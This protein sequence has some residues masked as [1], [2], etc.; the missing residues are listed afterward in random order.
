MLAFILIMSLL[1][2]WFGGQAYAASGYIINTIAGTNT[3]GYSGDGDAATS[4]SLNGPTGVAV[5]S[6]GNLY[7][8]D[9]LNHR[10][11]KV[12]ASGK[13]STVAGTGTGGYSGDEVTATSAYLN[14]PKGVAI[15][16]SG[17]LYIADT[18]SQRIRKVDV[19][20]KISTVAGNG[21]FGFGG[22][23]G[24]A[25]SA[26]LRD[27]DSVAVDS[28]GNLYI[29]DT[30]NY[31]IR[32]VD[33][34]GKISTV[35]GTG[36]IGNT[37]DGGD[38]TLA[39]VSLPTGISVDGSGNL[40][41]VSEFSIRKVDTSGKIS[42]VAGMY[43]YGF[44]GDGG[45]AIEAELYQPLVV[46]VDSS[47]NLYI[48]DFLNFRI[49]KVDISGKISTI[50]GTGR[51]D[52]SGDG[53]PAT[54]ADLYGPIGVAVDSNG[55]VYIADSY[56]NRIRK[57]SLT[58]QSVV[59]SADSSTPE[60][61]V[62]D[63]ITLT[64]KT[65][66]GNTDTSFNGMH[67]VT[68]S[69]YLQAPDNSYGSLNGMTLSAS[70]NTTSVMFQ[71][72]VASVNLK[73]NKA[74]EQTINLSVAD[75]ASPS[76]NALIIT[77]VAGSAASMALTTDIKAPASNGGLF[78]QQPVVRLL[79]AYGN[80]SVSD[81]STIVAVSRKDTGAWTLTGTA[82]AKA[83][84][85]VVAFSGLG[86]MNTAIVTGAKLSFE[87]AGLTPIESAAVTL[88]ASSYSGKLITRLWPVPHDPNHPLDDSDKFISM[89]GNVYLTNEPYADV[90]FETKGIDQFEVFVGDSKIAAASKDPSG[91]L[92]ITEGAGTLRMDSLDPVMDTYVLRIVAQPVVWTGNPIKI[93]A[94]SNG[95]I[96]SESVVLVQAPT[97]IS[98]DVP[99]KLETGKTITINGSTDTK[100]SVPITIQTTEET[101]TVFTDDQG[102]F[103]YGY[104]AP[105][106]AR[107]ETLKV[108]APGIGQPLVKSWSF[109]IYEPLMMVTPVTCNGTSGDPFLCQLAAIGGIGDRAWSIEAGSLPADVSLDHQTGLI[110]GTPISD[111]M[112]SI[113]VAVADSTGEKRT[114]TITIRIEPK[115]TLPAPSGVTAIAGD[116][117][118]ILSW[119]PVTGADYYDIYEGL[120][121]G[122]YQKIERI[123]NYTGS[124]SIQGLANDIIRYYAIKAGNHQIESDYSEEA[125]ATP[126]ALP[127]NAPQ[128][129]D[130]SE[131]TLSDITQTSIKLSWPS[132]MNNV[133]ITGYRVY[134][135]NTER[136]TVSGS[137]Y[138]TTV[139]GLRAATAYTF[140][141]IAYDAAGNESSPLVK[142]ATTAQASS[143]G[144]DSG[145]SS[146]GGGP[147]LSGNVD[148]EELRI[149][150]KDMNLELTLSNTAGTKR[151]TARTEAKQIEVIVKSSHLAA[152]VM[153]HDKVITGR[154]IVNLVEGENKLVFIVLAENGDKEEY[155]LIIHREAPKPSE[156][157]ISFT[158][159]AGHWAESY[160]KKAVASDIINGNT[161]GTF[162]PDAA[163]TRAEFT[164]M[165]MRMLKPEG[166]GAEL[167]FVDESSIGAWAKK[168]IAYA[169]KAQIV[170][171]YS[172]GH[173][174]PNAAISRVE[175]FVMTARALQLPIDQDAKADAAD[176]P[177]WANGA[178]E[179]LLRRLG[180]SSYP[181]TPGAMV[182][183][184][185]GVKMIIEVMQS[186]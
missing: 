153:L 166:I 167:S 14:R 5:D 11:R 30:G 178:V 97:V 126:R 78:A 29:A 89:S 144:N 43:D 103:T 20:G 9:T 174:R 61:G 26:E 73:L 129:P 165:L 148:L 22:D 94:T 86:A 96:E 169:V 79:D 182:T 133:G 75:V 161:D 6:R 124:Y 156:P 131:L 25:T 72:G 37:G 66:Q 45:P 122:S 34:S 125:N 145:G 13:I 59:A 85:G 111:G 116:G 23:G 91:N 58:A 1:P 118:V 70:P 177:Q 31:R 105:L 95:R 110:S 155:T 33:A 76:A 137:V 77:P 68:I 15:D 168:A 119:N 88:P 100:A 142:Q 28:K 176:I 115:A 69:G 60:V 52:F 107:N 158:D 81:N 38:A 147:L 93:Q 136:A 3:S 84:A 106:S 127:P 154:T 114:E 180:Y 49:R 113:T 19:S 138:G 132:V 149:W 82:T 130:G 10:I 16:S 101:I 51:Q 46:A 157:T 42:T 44:S 162:K 134:V 121:S 57:L 135:D 8:A 17:N 54:S 35:A 141:V 184:A 120:A 181:Y 24:P 48:S 150:D 112:Y 41:F 163:I 4:A 175:L 62:D 27:P 173:F 71:N 151:Y 159:I 102:H 65:A 39:Q 164:V 47:G 53:G 179:A 109:P 108:E 7:I 99:D 74:G 170:S 67:E 56:S 12:D 186:K 50:A 18:W 139:N 128:W 63:R 87:G 21:N 172:D 98:L 152:K 140:K 160:I 36:I 123:T 117:E 90:L 80:T 55:N 143:G 183:R 2:E 83:S 146:T 64:V 40:Y 92:V 104:T 171:G 32:K 185:E